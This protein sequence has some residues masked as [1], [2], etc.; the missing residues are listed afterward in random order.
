MTHRKPI[1]PEPERGPLTP[2]EHRKIMVEEAEASR[3]LIEF[4]R[5][6]HA[7]RMR[8]ERKFQS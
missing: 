1:K 3:R 2:Q 4:L 8:Q 6:Q 5:E 7:V